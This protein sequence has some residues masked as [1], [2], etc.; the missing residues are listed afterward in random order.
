MYNTDADYAD[1][2]TLF[3][4]NS[5]NAGRLLYLLEISAAKVGIHVNSNKTEFKT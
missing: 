5:S 2:I 3:S 4:E 1:D